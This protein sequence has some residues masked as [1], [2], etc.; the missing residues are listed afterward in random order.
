MRTRAREG[1]VLLKMG[2]VFDAEFGPRKGEEAFYALLGLEEGSFE[3]A[4]EP[5]EGE[6]VIRRPMSAL[7]IE[8]LRRMDEARRGS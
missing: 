7:L 1:W 4:N 8:G 2:A 3:F 6:P 5:V